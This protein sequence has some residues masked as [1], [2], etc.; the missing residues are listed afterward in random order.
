MQSSTF[1]RKYQEEIVN[2]NVYVTPFDSDEEESDAEE[3]ADGKYEHDSDDASFGEEQNA[4]VP[5]PPTGYHPNP[6][7][8]YFRAYLTIQGGK[9]LEIIG[10]RHFTPLL[11]MGCSDT[12][13]HLSSGFMR[14]F[15]P[16]RNVCLEAYEVFGTYALSDGSLLIHARV[17]VPR[18]VLAHIQ[19]CSDLLQSFARKF[20][21]H[22]TP[23][24]D[25]MLGRS[26]QGETWWK[27]KYLTHLTKKK[28]RVVWS[29]GEAQWISRKD[30]CG[31]LRKRARTLVDRYQAQK[32]LP[33]VVPEEV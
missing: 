14:I 12:R 1:D 20:R 18:E 33:G 10:G 17:G 11:L 32:R 21:P 23:D 19:L 28:V 25:E 22:K 2:G 5:V 7:R 24:G 27:V 4:N 15:D 13:A 3:S 9:D 30:L 8:A 6:F 26:K 31:D 16:E 29:S